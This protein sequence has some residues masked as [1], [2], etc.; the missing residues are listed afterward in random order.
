MNERDLMP[1]TTNGKSLDQASFSNPDGAGGE[2]SGEA[3]APPPGMLERVP[4]DIR[5][6]LPDEGVEELVSGAR[7]E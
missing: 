4:E 7:A 6:Q 5:R 3:P 1:S 2:P